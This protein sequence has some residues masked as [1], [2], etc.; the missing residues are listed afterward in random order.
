MKLVC[1]KPIHSES[2]GSNQDVRDMLVASMSDKNK[3]TWSEGL[4][5]NQS[6]KTS[7]AFRHQDEPLWGYVWNGAEDRT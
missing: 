7:F 2:Q 3:K 4:R 1:R 6:K 5:F